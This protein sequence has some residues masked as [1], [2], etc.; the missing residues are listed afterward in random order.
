VVAVVAA[1]LLAMSGAAAHD[2]SLRLPGTQ[3]RFGTSLVRVQREL[4]LQ[5]APPAA[6]RPPGRSAPGVIAWQAGVRFFGLAGAATL[7]FEDS[8]LVRASIIVD[9]PSPHDI[10]YVE[11]DLV[12]Q[13]FRRRCALRDGLNRRCEWTAR[14]RVRLSTSAT[15]LEAVLEPLG[16]PLRP[17]PAAGGAIDAGPPGADPAAPALPETLQLSLPAPAG[18]P[19]TPGALPW[20]VV[21]DSCHAIRP[22]IAR[23][24]GV[25]G[26]VLVEVSVDTGGRVVAARVSRGVPMLDEAALACAR[27]YR[28]A[29]YLWRGRAHPFRVTLPIRFTL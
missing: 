20:P 23:Q 3:L 13:G 2:T 11:D 21:L 29:P 10:D 9:Q 15:S 27:G 19:G 25:F 8:V 5:V 1:G 28:F 4:A 17:A 26:R 7:E 16:K 6:A 18:A 24:S 14:A 22:E 12:R